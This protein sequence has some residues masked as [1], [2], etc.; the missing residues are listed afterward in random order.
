MLRHLPTMTQP[1]Q[2]HTPANPQE[3]KLFV[4]SLPPDISKED[5]GSLLASCLTCIFFR[6]KLHA[7]N[8]DGLQDLWWALRCPCDLWRQ[9]ALRI[10]FK[11]SSL[12]EL[13]YFAPG[14]RSATG[15]ACD[16]SSD[17]H[18]EDTRKILS[19]QETFHQRSWGVCDV[20]VQGLRRNSN[21]GKEHRSLFQRFRNATR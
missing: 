10:F 13:S 20:Q 4:G 21:P 12:L 16:W 5:G 9:W 8:R 15:Q 11:S 18:K 1:S 2:P 19:F 6:F 7:G 14:N 17:R 3:H